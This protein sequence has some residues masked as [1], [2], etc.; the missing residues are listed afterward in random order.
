MDVDLDPP[1]PLCVLGSRISV[2]A[3]KEALGCIGADRLVPITR[4]VDGCAH[5]G[6]NG[7]AIELFLC[8]FTD[9]DV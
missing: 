6:A 7:A 8:Y 3:V 4:E 1:E 2:K 5:V 9:V